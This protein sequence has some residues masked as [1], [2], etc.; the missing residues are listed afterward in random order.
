MADA[1]QSEFE[2]VW[3]ISVVL[4]TLADVCFG[5]KAITNRRSRACVHQRLES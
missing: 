1:Q 5:P 3:V 4:G 2:R